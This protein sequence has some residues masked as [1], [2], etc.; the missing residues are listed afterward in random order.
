MFAI[1]SF[2]RTAE[3][4]A[5][6][7]IAS[8]AWPSPNSPLRV[9]KR[10]RFAPRNRGRQLPTRGLGAIQPGASTRLLSGTLVPRARLARSDRQ[11]RRW[12]QLSLPRQNNALPSPQQCP[13][14]L[15]GQ[16][17]APDW[18]G[19]LSGRRHTGRFLSG[20]ILSRLPD[21]QCYLRW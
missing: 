14:V 16:I 19:R 7:A 6:A 1:C 11:I 17:V 3:R 20:P 18:I 5:W 21:W 4:S 12:R 8:P 9:R 15:G 13:Y 2:W 10:P